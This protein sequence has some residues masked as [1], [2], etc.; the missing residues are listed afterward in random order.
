LRGYKVAEEADD[1]FSKL[2]VVGLVSMII[3]QVFVNMGAI[4]GLLP[5]TGLPLI[6]ISQGGTALAAALTSVGIILAVSRN[7]SRR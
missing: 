5:L 6:F 3:A 4:V 2:L 1:K 7:Q